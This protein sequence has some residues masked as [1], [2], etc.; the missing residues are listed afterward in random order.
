MT[1]APEVFLP[2]YDHDA[3]QQALQQAAV[4]RCELE[5][6]R[7]MALERIYQMERRLAEVDRHLM[8][9][10]PHRGLSLVHSPRTDPARRSAAPVAKR[11]VRTGT[12]RRA[13]R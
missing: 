12:S 4:A 10:A 2:E 9:E 5:E 11:R 8:L 13:T 7:I 1:T 3:C 6:A